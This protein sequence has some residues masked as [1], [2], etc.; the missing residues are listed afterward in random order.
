MLL[1]IVSIWRAGD[2]A[3]NFIG[4]L[5]KLQP[6]EPKVEK[7]EP[8]VQRL[9][10]IQELST[11]VLT[12]ETIVPTSAERKI[13]EIPLA[14]TRLLYVARGEIRAGIDLSELQAT[15]IKRSNN[16]LEINLPAAKN[17]R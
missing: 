6:V 12:T 8:I 9:K 5:F 13:G 16:Q 17:I 1:I 11:M 3:L 14:T 4:S 10:N 2:R 7:L 15:D